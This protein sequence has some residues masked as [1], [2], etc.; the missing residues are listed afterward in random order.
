MVLKL[1]TIDQANGFK[2]QV[3]D[4]AQLKIKHRFEQKYKILEVL[5]VPVIGSP[6]K[7]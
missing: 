5:V 4:V 7:N 6:L 2:M 3:L 1:K